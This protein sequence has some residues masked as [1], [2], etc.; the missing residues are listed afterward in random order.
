MDVKFLKWK[1]YKESGMN[2]QSIL[3]DKNGKWLATG[4]FQFVHTTRVDLDYDK[5]MCKYSVRKQLEAHQKYC[6]F[7]GWD[8]HAHKFNAAERGFRLYMIGFQPKHFHKSDDFVLPL[9]NRAYTLNKGLDHNK[10]GVITIGEVRIYW[11]RNMGR[12]DAIIAQ[13]DSKYG[14][15]YDI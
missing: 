7:F 14:H 9:S 4:L 8:R 15:L 5:P 13:K 2:P 12:S 10:D 3:K 1:A 11:T 6:E